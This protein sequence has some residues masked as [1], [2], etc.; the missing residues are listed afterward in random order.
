M[1]STAGRIFVG[2]RVRERVPATRHRHH[3][4]RGEQ[5]LLGFVCSARISSYPRYLR[6]IL[7][8]TH[9]CDHITL[10]P[11]VRFMTF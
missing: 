3:V 11:G 8:F 6:A 2:G 1:K 4:R 10:T 9:L 7:N 5:C